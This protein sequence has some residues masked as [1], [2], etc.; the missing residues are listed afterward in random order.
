M[1]SRQNFF[2]HYYTNVGIVR[3]DDL[4]P[5]YNINLYSILHKR[6]YSINDLY[7]RVNFKFL[8]NSNVVKCMIWSQYL[9]TT[10]TCW[11]RDFVTLKLF[12][13]LNTWF[14]CSTAP[15][16]HVLQ[17]TMQ[18]QE[19]IVK[20]NLSDNIKLLI[21]LLTSSKPSSKS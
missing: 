3:I 2:I 10:F 13:L 19:I 21:N 14:R 16:L 1:S 8:F 20:Q 6:S 17:N 15:W 12:H 9:L 4:C 7:P 5:K 18:T 11:T